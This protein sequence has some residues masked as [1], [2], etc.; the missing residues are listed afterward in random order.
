MS[1]EIELKAWVDDAASA[2]KALA[3]FAVKAG[4]FD[5]DDAYWLPVP[6]LGPVTPASPDPHRA[7][8][9]LGSGVRIRKEGATAIINYKNKEVR[10]GIEVNDER[11]FEVSD[12]QAFEGLLQRLGLAVHLRKRKRG[13]AWRAGEILIELAEVE[14]LGLFVEIEILAESDGEAIVESARERLLAVLDR[15]GVDRR[16]IESRYYSEMLKESRRLR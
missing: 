16:R 2:R 6:R 3:L 14:G 15:L 12:V 11:E 8:L 9:T 10:S 4:D 1:I 13:E 7:A 5:K